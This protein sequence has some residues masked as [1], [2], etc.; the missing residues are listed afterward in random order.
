MSILQ[1]L[2]PILV[3]LKEERISHDDEK[4][5]GSGNCHV[6]SFGIDQ[7]SQSSSRFSVS[8]GQR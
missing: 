4:S 6:E 1:Y 5:F 8:S 2:V 7:E 3:L